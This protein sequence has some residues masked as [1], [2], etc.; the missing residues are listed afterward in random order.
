M[1]RGSK[2]IKTRSW[3][4]GCSAQCCLIGLIWWICS[5]QAGIGSLGNE[6]LDVV[7]SLLVGGF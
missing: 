5:I 7:V 6:E 1:G 3:R 2:G 4:L